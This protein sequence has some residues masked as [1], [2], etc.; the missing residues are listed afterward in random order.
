MQRLT[1]ITI[2]APQR[3]PEWY[4]ARLGCVTA[5]EVFKVMAY[6]SV[7]DA[8]IKQAT[9]IYVEHGID[10]E[11]ILEVSEKWP[12]KFVTDVGIEL[13][14]TSARLTYRQDLVA[15]RITKMRGDDDRYIT[16]DMKRG[17]INEIAAKSIYADQ[18]GNI[19]KD[20]LF[21]THPHLMLGASPDGLVIDTVTGELGNAEI[22]CLKSRNHLYKVIDMDEVP[23]DYIDQIQLQMFIDGRDWCDF[24][25]YDKRVLEDLQLFI[26]RVSYDKFYVEH[27]MLPAI[28]KFL[29]ECDRDERRFYAIAKAKRE[30]LQAE[31]AARLVTA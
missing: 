22:K 20:A 18:T 6:Y 19:I 28:L 29:D 8:M 27:V 10:E 23:A 17:I 3:S 9:E 12:W 15:E 1:P 31:I 14:E 21:M 7:T 2:N 24:I 30:K 13:Q 5:S 16:Q 11:Y 4:A 26:K 25:A